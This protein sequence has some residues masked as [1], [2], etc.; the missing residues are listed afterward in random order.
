MKQQPATAS[1]TASLTRSATAPKKAQAAKSSSS[2][3]AY[4]SFPMPD[5]FRG[6]DK[7]AAQLLIDYA[8]YQES[9]AA[10]EEQLREIK[11]ALAAIADKYGAPGIRHESLV[12][13]YG[14]EKTRRTLSRTMLLENGV[15]P[16]QIEASY[17]DSKPYLDVRVVDLSKPKK[18]QKDGIGDE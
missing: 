2:S 8:T 1:A 5:Q 13:Y 17:Q 4:E 14:G 16:E 12:M 7:R 6:P 10:L 9:K 11:S 18:G 3:P 15:T